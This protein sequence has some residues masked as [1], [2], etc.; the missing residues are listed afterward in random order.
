MQAV[1]VVGAIVTTL[2]TGSLVDFFLE[3]ERIPAEADRRTSL[4]HRFFRPA[5]ESS[6]ALSARA[7]GSHLR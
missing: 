6:A 7:I 4:T 1:F 3:K 2:M 5:R